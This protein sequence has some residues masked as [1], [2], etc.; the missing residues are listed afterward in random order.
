MPRFCLAALA[1]VLIAGCSNSGSDKP[2]ETSGSASKPSSGTSA[3]AKRGTIGVS[4]LTMDN[5]FFKDM[6]E[7][8]KAEAAKSGYDVTLVAGEKDPARQRDQVSDFIESKV[9]AIILSPCDSR[10]VGAAIQKANAAGIPVFTADIAN[11]DKSAKVVSHVATDNYA[12]GKLA[13]EAM[14]EALKGHGKVAIIDFPEVESVILR[15][16]GF[17][18]V[19]AKSPGIQIVAQLQGGAARDSAYKTAQDIL[20]KHADLDGFFCINDPTAF[21]AIAA[22]E[23]AGRLDKVKIISFDGQLEAKKAVK[24]GKIYAEPIQYPDKIGATAVQSIVKY[25]SGEKVPPEILVPTSLYRKADADSD[26]ALK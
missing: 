6:G 3:P 8:I 22:L 19:V 16:K 14:V 7:T 5:P 2:S 15:T 20:E 23:K 13:G 17:R 12:G 21:G 4:L 11:L 26:P 25:L 24:E 10:S 9:S 18:E 1:L